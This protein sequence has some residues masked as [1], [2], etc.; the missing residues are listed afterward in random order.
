MLLCLASNLVTVASQAGKL[1]DKSSS[2]GNFVSKFHIQPAA[3]IF[4]A[5]FDVRWT[6]IIIPQ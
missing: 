6:N 2:F 3:S 4:N 1:E 5:V